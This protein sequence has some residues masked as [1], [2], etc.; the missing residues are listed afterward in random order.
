MQD[1][2]SYTDAE[3]VVL[4]SQ[5][6][7]S[8]FD[9]L[10]LRNWEDLYKSAYYILRDQEASKDIVQDVFVWLWK[11][12]ETVKIALVKSYLR[13][14]VKFKVANYIRAGKIR[15]K[16]FD[17]IISFK[18]THSL[19]QSDELAEVRDLNIIIQQAVS[20]L[21]EKC[22]EVYKLSREAHLSNQEIAN[23]LDISVKTVENQM[24]IAL[25]RLRSAIEVYLIT[26]LILQAVI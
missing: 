19:S 11:H 20:L 16:F 23:R 5:S 9:A 7:K 17:E 2:S 8:A 24:T 13:A 22:R 10:Y 1:Y 14:A 12:R 6:D 4:L 18:P 25:R 15:E 21:P 26:Y 3:L